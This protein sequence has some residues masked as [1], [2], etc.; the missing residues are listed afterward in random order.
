MAV[1]F[2]GEDVGGHAVKE[3]AIVRDDHD[4]AGEIVEAFFEGLQGFH[5]EVVGRFVE[6]EQVVA[7]LQHLGEVDAVAL[8]AREDADL[9]LLVGALEVEGA[10]IGA[11]HDGDA[12]EVDH[13]G[14]AGDFFPD[15]LVGV[16]LVA[17]LVHV[18]DLDRLAD[19]HGALVRFFLAEDHL[20]QRRLAGAVRADDADDAAGG[21]LEGEV[22]DQDVV[23][24]GLGE[25]FRFQH[26][27][28][29]TGA[30]RD[31]DL[32]GH[33]LLALGLG[34]HLLIGV[35]T[36]LGFGLAG[37]LAGADPFE[38]LGEGALAADIVARLLLHAFRLLLDPAGIVALERVAAAAVEFEDP[39]GDVVEEVA[40]VR[41]EDDAAGEVDQ[42]VLQ[43]GD[44]F[45]VEVVGRFV[46][47]DHVGL[48][49][50]Q[51]ADGDA[52]DFA[53]REGGDVGIVFRAAQGVHRHL[54][55]GIDVPGIGGVDLLLQRGHL[56]HQLV[57]IVLAELF[58]DRVELVDH[59]LF[60]TGRGDVV[61][62]V[63]R[64][65]EFR[66]LRQVADLDALGGP[67]LADEVLIDAGHDA[68]EGRFTRAVDTDDADLGIRQEVQV[69]VFKH[70]LAAGIGLGEALHVKDELGTGHGRR[71]L[72]RHENGISAR[73]D[74]PRGEDQALSAGGVRAR[75]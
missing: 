74:A 52:A 43:P 11:R 15:V 51:L 63:F 4:A 47:Q 27:A 9:L 24:E 35:D 2:E 21:Q 38:F 61:E 46:H 58:G 45:G 25:V 23:A 42:E 44:G 29:E 3:P 17:A 48:R 36:R 66:L 68:Q 59:D 7:A 20:E 14:A 32:R 6:E 26:D 18:A 30:G 41:D 53:A 5:V 1:A 39:V 70:L 8:T 55:L 37:F 50:E 33:D 72:C 40:V 22:V 54:D 73:C 65:V 13:V 10:D 64:G 34:G 28:A 71:F 67:G 62:H 60:G 31:A 56:L 12:A 16:E 19:A 69:D 57:G 75:G 49:Q